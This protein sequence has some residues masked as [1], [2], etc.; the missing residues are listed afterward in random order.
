MK[1]DEDMYKD[2]LDVFQIA[3][4]RHFFEKSMR[5]SHVCVHMKSIDNGGVFVSL[6]KDEP[7]VTIV[8]SGWVQLNH[9]FFWVKGHELVLLGPWT[10]NPD[11]SM[12]VRSLVSKSFE[13]FLSLARK[14]ENDGCCERSQ[15]TATMA[16]RPVLFVLVATVHA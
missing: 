2:P 14:L 15:Q 8:F 16:Q 5:R 4:S 1:I 11:S 10:S 13:I 6:I 9:F 3:R 12:L 7:F